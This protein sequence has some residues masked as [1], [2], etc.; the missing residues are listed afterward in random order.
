MKIV[1]IGGSGLIGKQLVNKLE[2]SGN[3]VVAAS[4]S[5]GINSITGE[6][7]ASAFENA[8]AVI[9]VTNSPVYD[10][11]GLMDFF[12]NSTKNLITEAKKAG[13]KHFVVLSILGTNRI[14]GSAYMNAKQAQEKLVRESGLP[15]T[16]V[17]SAQFYEFLDSIIAMAS[18]DEL[19][20]LPPARFQPIAASEVVDFLANTASRPAVNATIELAGPDGYTIAELGEL[21][22][23]RNQDKRKVITDEKAQYG[24]AV[25]D[26]EAMAPTKDAFL[27]KLSFQQWYEL[28]GKA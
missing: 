28:K 12:T 9:D 10:E 5:L 1:V 18:S 17:Q 21:L 7:L 14:Q 11:Q 16:I 8:E 23:A 26:I 24:G 4:P 6:G 25:I 20:K 3:Q 19:V 22:L 13:I 2:A 27:T 15:Y